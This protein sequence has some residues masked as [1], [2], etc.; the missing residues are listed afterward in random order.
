MSALPAGPA[1]SGAFWPGK[2]PLEA[3]S[4]VL[5]ELTAAPEGTGLPFVP[6]LADRGPWADPVGRTVALL[7]EPFAELGPHGWRLADRPGGDLERARSLLAQDLDALAVAG[8][9]YRGP[10]VLSVTGPWTLAATLYLARG[11]R[12]VSDAGAVREVT[13][14]LAEAVARLVRAVQG[15]LPGV[16]AVLRLDERLLGQVRAGVLPTFSGHARLR[17]VDGHVLAD[18]LRTVLGV[19]ADTPVAVTVGAGAAG[20]EPAVHAGPAA[21]GIDLAASGGAGAAAWNEGLWTVLAGAVE[22][23]TGIWAGLPPVGVS[24]CSGP[25]VRLLADAV[26]VPWRRIGLPVRDL[27]RVVLSGSSAVGAAPDVQAARG[28]LAARIQ[29]ARILAELAHG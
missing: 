10:L 20:L 23:G 17:A 8:H 22:H 6:I 21:V 27:G 12:V 16:E 5:G 28:E 1:A 14:A 4:V 3:L 15:L 29:A 13:L 11:D 26:A 2:D 25:Q 24:Q 19:V 9:G 18:G 7:E